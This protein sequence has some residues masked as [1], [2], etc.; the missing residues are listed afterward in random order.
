[1]LDM[2]PLGLAAQPA[3]ARLLAA[4]MAAAVP[5]WHMACALAD[6]RGGARSQRRRRCG[7][8]LRGQCCENVVFET[9]CLRAFVRAYV[10]P[11]LA[12]EVFAVCGVGVPLTSTS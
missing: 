4:A 6:G 12:L 10:C 7:I 8:S 2:R 9:A 3:A 1:M 5:L 11:G